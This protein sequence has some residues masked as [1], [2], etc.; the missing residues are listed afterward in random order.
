MRALEGVCAQEPE[1][2]NRLEKFQCVQLLQVFLMSRL[3]CYVLTLRL[4]LGFPLQLSSPFSPHRLVSEPASVHSAY[5]CSLTC[6]NSLYLQ[7]MAEERAESH[8]NL[9][10]NVAKREERKGGGE[11]VEKGWQEKETQ[12]EEGKKVKKGRGEGGGRRVEQI[13]V[14]S[15]SRLQAS[16]DKVKGGEEERNH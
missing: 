13:K 15:C 6:T 10:T 3:L 7:A 8:N 16:E 4:V 14:R 11:C 2:N 9:E 12:R 5:L 1:V